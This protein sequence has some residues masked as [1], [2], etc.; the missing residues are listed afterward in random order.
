MSDTEPVPEEH[1]EPVQEEHVETVQEVVETITP[2]EY[3]KKEKEQIKK[4]L[5]EGKTHDVYELKQLKNGTQRLEKK[6]V[7]TITEKRVKEQTETVSKK[8]PAQAYM[9]DTQLL[10]QNYSDLK[11]RVESENVLL[12]QKLKKYKRRFEELFEDDVE[13]VPYEPTQEPVQEQESTPA[14]L[15]RPIRRGVIPKSKF[16]K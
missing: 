3:T 6:K 14:P 8:M 7:Q 10:W 12:R 4:D 9:T 16:R 13:E 15:I 5:L 1:I 11:T 2:K